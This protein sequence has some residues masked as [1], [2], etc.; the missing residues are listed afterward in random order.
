MKFLGC[1]LVCLSFCAASEN[2]DIAR[3]T[4]RQSLQS[5]HHITIQ[6]GSPLDADNEYIQ[7]FL[8]QDICPMIVST[9]KIRAQRNTVNNREHYVVTSSMDNLR[10]VSNQFASRSGLI[11]FVIL[12][13]IHR[14][15]LTDIF[16]N[17]WRKLRVSKTY[18][19]T[20]SGISLYDPFFYDDQGNYGR[21]ADVESGD[22]IK[23]Y[24]NMNGYPLRIQIFRSVYS[25]LN[26]DESNKVA[27]AEG[28]DAKVAYLLAQKMNFTMILQEPDPNRFG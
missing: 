19:L 23:T 28:A 13:D 17:L 27:S 5:I 24:S 20:T 12:D 9:Y 26:F 2:A 14:E 21:I 10:V 3:E 25:K 6:L 11:F 15:I 7:L 8:H 18:F 4:I 1:F 22:F 16:R